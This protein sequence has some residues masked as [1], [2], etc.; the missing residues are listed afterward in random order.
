MNETKSPGYMGVKKL[1]SDLSD[2]EK[3]FWLK[4]I[5]ACVEGIK[6]DRG[7]FAKRW[8]KLGGAEDSSLN[9]SKR[10]KYGIIAT[11]DIARGGARAYYKLVDEDGT[12][13][14]LRELG[15]L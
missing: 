3:D 1:A 10:K 7:E 13:E 2:Q 15:Y 4:A 8:L 11:M 14:A 5:K 12:R 6:N 9:L